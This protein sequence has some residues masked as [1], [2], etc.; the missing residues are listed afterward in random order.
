MF[1]GFSWSD[2]YECEDP[3]DLK[4]NTTARDELGHGCTKFGGQKFEDV[5]F[6]LVNCTVL[7][8]IE[9]YGNRTFTITVPCIK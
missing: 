4:G 1:S 3:L 8:N 2:F 7:P 5:H 9:C 6:T